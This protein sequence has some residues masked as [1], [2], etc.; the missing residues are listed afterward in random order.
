MS[1]TSGR[2]LRP[3]STRSRYA[4]LCSSSARRST[5]SP[6]TSRSR[7]SSARIAGGDGVAGHVVRHLGPE[8]DGADAG[9]TECDLEDGLRA[10]RP[11]VVGAQRADLLRDRATRRGGEHRDRAPVRDRRRHPAERHRELHVELLRDLDELGGD[12][13][14][15]DRR[16]GTGDDDDVAPGVTGHEVDGRPLDLAGHAVDQLHRRT[17]LLQVEQ[18][19]RGRSTRTCAASP[20]PPRRRPACRCRRAHRRPNR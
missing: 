13:P 4:S 12:V 6:A 19:A 7:S 20:A 2:S 9:L 11:E 16:L 15:A 3:S 8:P 17:G 14:P 10:G 1:A 5:V 18:V